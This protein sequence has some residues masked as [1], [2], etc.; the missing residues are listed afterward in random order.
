LRG[1]VP[2]LLCGGLVLLLCCRVSVA[3]SV[4]LAWDPILSSILGGYRLSYGETRG[5]YATTVDVGNTTSY[6]LSGLLDGHTYYLAVKAY[7]L[8]GLIESSYSNEV[9]FSVPQPITVDFTASTTTG[10]ASLAV[11]FT[12]FTSGTVTNWNWSFPGSF[13]PTVS[14]STPDVVTATYPTPGTYSVSLS[15]QGPSGSAQQTKTDLITVTS[16]PPPP[17]APTPPPS[18]SLVG[19]VAAYGFEE[20][21]GTTVIDSS[22]QG[23]NGT[24]KEAVRISNGHYGKALKFDGVND[25]VTVPDSNSLDLSTGLTLEAWV[26]PLSLTIGGKTVIMKQTFGGAVYDLYA[27]DDQDVPIW[28]FYNGLYRVISGPQHLP[29]NQW[30]HLVGTF[31][32]L[33]QRLYINGVEVAT[34]SE[35]GPIITS[36]GNLRIGGNSIWGEYFDG[37][38]DEVRIYNRALS[39]TEVTNNLSSPVIPAP[40]PA[41]AGNLQGLVA[42]Y[43]FDEAGGT[44]VFDASGQNN[45][46]TIT[47]AVR[48]ANGRYGNALQ[49]DGVTAWVTIPDSPSLDLST[50]LTLEAWVYPQ[51]QSNGART[52]ILKETPGGAVYTLYANYT[53]FTTQYINFPFS[54]FFNGQ[55]R[56]VKGS[57]Q[58]PANQWTHLASTYDGQ[59]QKFYING[60]QIDSRSETALINTSNGVLRIG[61]N[62]I[63][64]EYFV[65]Y[66]DEVR[67]YNRGLSDV[68]LNSDLATPVSGST[69][70]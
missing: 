60:G 34:R 39:A 3:G 11:N 43:G 45:N 10:P 50:G 12:P 29:L 23:N 63:W 51:S 26:Y 19:L 28:S 62:S 70:P 32:G 8:S 67:V 58:L 47:D 7:G 25:W 46:G 64:G 49:F 36:T 5:T 66:I 59:T 22:G 18:A 53:I 16:P 6:T 21:S 56:V 33:Y 30:T 41:P 61:G 13:T 38:I 40:A 54:S 37:Y 65:G 2:R 57:S 42:A 69:P 48:T 55:Y 20:A 9:S 15:V 14:L 44:T 27:N 4:N 17:P 52:A 35:N 24:I 31:D 68:E 1:I